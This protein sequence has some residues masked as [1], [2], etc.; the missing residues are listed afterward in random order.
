VLVFLTIYTKVNKVNLRIE[1]TI[2]FNPV[3][4]KYIISN[5]LVINYLAIGNNPILIVLNL[6]LPLLF[7]IKYTY[8]LLTL[9]NRRYIASTANN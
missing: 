3:I 4:V 5:L 9:I 2:N 6:T 1:V 8:K 7:N